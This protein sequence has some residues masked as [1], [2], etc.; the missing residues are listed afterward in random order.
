VEVMTQC[1][2]YFGRK[3]KAGGAVE[4]MKL[5]KER[6]ARLGSKQATEDKILQGVFVE[7]HQPEYCE[8][9]ENIIRSAVAN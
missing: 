2:T 7:Q 1:P 5:F 9:Y 4:M 6:T 3:N 8:Q